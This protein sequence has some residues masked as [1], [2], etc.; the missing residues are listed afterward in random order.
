MF[1]TVKNRIIFTVLILI[2]SIQVVSAFIQYVQVRSVFF[3]EFVL[4]AQGLSQAPYIELNKRMGSMALDSAA[5]TGEQ[6]D[7]DAQII[8]NIELFINLIQPT[9][10]GDILT[11]REDL[12]GI[13]YVDKTGKVINYSFKKTEEGE[14]G[15][16]V[17]HFN[18]TE[19]K[20]L[21]VIDVVAAIVKKA[22]LTAVEEGGQ[23][24]IVVPYRLNDRPYG[25]LVMIYSDMRILEARNKIFLNMALTTFIALLVFIPITWFVSSRITKPIGTIVHRLKDIAEGEGDLTV[26]LDASKKDEFGELSFWFNTFMEK[27]QVIIRDITENAKSLN[28]SAVSL[29]DL[30]Q[31]MSQSAD[32]MSAKT[33]TVASASEEMSSNIS[34]VSAAM[35]QTATNANLVAAAIEEMTATIN[36]IAH[37]SEKGRDI[38]SDAVFK[39]KSASERVGELGKDAMEIG[40]VTETITEISEQTNLLALNATIE[41]ARV[42]ESGKGFAVVANEIKELARQTAIATLEIKEKIASIQNSTAGTVSE[43][44]EIT[45]VIHEV[46]DIVA[47]IAASVEEQSVTAKEVATNINQISTGIQEVNENVAQSS[48]VSTEI[49]RDIGEA[50][51]GVSEISN[52][53]SQVNSSAEELSL[54]AERLNHMVG[55]FK[56]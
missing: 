45:K 2:L 8:E 27:I 34:S 23:V 35:E 40:K 15:R 25:G 30:S 51:Q 36:E 17:V 24:N 29:S 12:L 54:L 42:G 4:G 11:S 32:T 44:E 22:E 10:F 14:D 50:N 37:N 18:T 16:E 21:A 48:T 26:R 46:N 55:R 7:A 9:L 47:T 49:A 1:T 38:S 19:K 41:A 56:A 3:N 31:V 52:S 28:A 43:I 13:K 39:V 5:S 6:Q 53:S 33:D 20:D